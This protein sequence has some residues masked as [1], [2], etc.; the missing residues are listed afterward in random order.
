MLEENREN[1]PQPGEE[2]TDWYVP[3]QAEPQEVE[4]CYVSAAPLPERIRPPQPKKRPRK[5]LWIC[6]ALA[7]GLI[8]AAI[9]LGIFLVGHARRKAPLPD[10][11][12]SKASSIFNI[13]NEEEATKIRRTELNDEVELTINDQAEELTPQEIYKK[14]SP[15]TVIVLAQ[16]GE[17]TT[18]GTG[19]IMT[20]DGY[21]ITNAHVIAGGESVAIALYGSYLY[22][23]ELVG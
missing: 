10:M 16:Q 1:T 2:I 12:D 5:V 13:F 23:A 8:I 21:I 18:V 4:G 3:R 22:E 20:D 19:V 6:L 9:V 17:N 15:A 11:D 14:V 7:A